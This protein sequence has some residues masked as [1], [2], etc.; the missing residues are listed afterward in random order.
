MCTNKRTSFMHIFARVAP[1]TAYTLISKKNSFRAR[2]L[3]RFNLFQS[4]A[5]RSQFWLLELAEPFHDLISKKNNLR[6][7]KYAVLD[8]FRA[9]PPDPNSGFLSLRHSNYQIFTFGPYFR[10]RQ[11]CFWVSLCLDLVGFQW[12]VAYLYVNLLSHLH[13]TFYL[14]LRNA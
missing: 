3:G 10:R 14:R 2:I 1:R 5:S 11:I 9:Q 7:M 13:I 12:T 6:A 4:S 8:Y